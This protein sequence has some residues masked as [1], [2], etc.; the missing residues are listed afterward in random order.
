M[1]SG[2]KEKGRQININ[3]AY[4]NLYLE[5]PEPYGHGRSFKNLI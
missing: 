2:N 3:G 1:I 4:I 5:I